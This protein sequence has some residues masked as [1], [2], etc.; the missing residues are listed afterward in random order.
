MRV[1]VTGAGGFVGRRLVESLARAGHEPLAVTRQ[2]AAVPHAHRTARVGSL[3]DTAALAAALSG[4]EAVVHLAARVHMMNEEASEADDAHSRANVGLTRSVLEAAR[5]VGATRFLFLSSAKVQGEGRP[6]PYTEQDAP[7]PEDAYAR[8]KLAA[9]EVVAA[10]GDPIAWTILRPPLVYGPDVKGNLRR[11]LRLAQRSARWPLPLG[12]IDNRRSLISLA[13]LCDAIIRC[14]THADAAGRRFLVSDADD[15]STS[16]L[17]RRIANAMGLR[18]RLLPVP[19][20]LLRTGLALVGKRAEGDRLVGSFR[21]DPSL[22]M[23]TLAWT[24]PQRVD[25]GIRE[26]VDAWQAAR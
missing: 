20:T 10:V 1:A 11:L 22:I 23:R 2:S 7:A 8:S 15:L 6:T 18:P 13:N 3:E 17:V 21:V 24:P 9:E 14:L 19:G 26:M 5:S 12:S 4:S 16:D 25:D